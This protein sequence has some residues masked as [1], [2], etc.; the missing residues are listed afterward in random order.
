MII[1][2][3][4]SAMNA[5]RRNNLANLQTD[6]SMGKLASGYRINHAGDDAAGLAISE[7]M[8][9]Q[10]GGLQQA[11]RNAQDGISFIQTT[12]GFL[13]TTN[14]ILKRLRN[15]AV[16]ASNGIA[17]AEDRQQ[18]QVEVSQ[19]VDE[20]DRVAS[21]GQFNTMNMLLGDFSSDAAGATNSMWIHLGANVD[22][23]ERVYIGT[24][25]ALALGVRDN[26]TSGAISLETAESANQAIATLDKALQTVVRQR[27][28]L[29]AYQNRL[30]AAIEGIDIAA[31][32]MQAAESRIRDLDMASEVVN[33]TRDMILGQTSNAMLAQAN[34]R[35]Q[36]VLQL[37]Q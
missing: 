27:A 18:I 20:V 6:K 29:G 34:Q 21:Q 9:A 13:E 7:K 31:V 10:I 19:L 16:Q 8:R 26:G 1:N 36:M 14:S 23:R 33:Y 37:L 28:D 12:E 35:P 25:T 5:H 4:L 11:S 2:H 24:M 32:N 30:E 22:Q 15:L 17:T 3:N